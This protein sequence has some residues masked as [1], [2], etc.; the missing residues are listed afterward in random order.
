MRYSRLV[1][2]CNDNCVGK[3][4]ENVFARKGTLPV[5]SDNVA[6]TRDTPHG[7]ERW[8]GVHGWLGP[9]CRQDWRGVQGGRCGGDDGQHGD[10]YQVELSRANLKG[11]T[12]ERPG[13]VPPAKLC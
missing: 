7:G 8:T 10:F 11:K 13:N 1:T 12:D 4:W 9:D 6:L 5:D 2:L 3:L